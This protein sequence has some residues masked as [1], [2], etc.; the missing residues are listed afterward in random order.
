M[1][2]A[3]AFDN[4]NRLTSI[5]SQPSGAG[6][7][8][9]S[10]NYQYNQADQRTHAVLADGTYWDYSYDSL[11][12]VTNGV[13]RWA[14]DNT[15]VAGQDY[16]YA[17]DD[18]GNRTSAGTTA[19]ASVY[20]A[21]QLNQCTQRTVPGV[22]EISGSAASAGMVT[23]NNSPTV[24]HG[25]YFY[26]GISVPNQVSA[27]WTQLNVVAVLKNAGSNQQDIVTQTTGHKFV[28]KTPEP[29]FY[30][31]DGSLTND[32]RWVYAWD[33]ENRLASMQ[34]DTNRA[35]ASVPVTR[36]EF[37]YDA[38]SRR[39]GKKVLTGW[40]NSSF[41]V[42][43]TTRFLYDGW[44][45]IAEI[46][47]S[48]FTNSY[49]WGLDLSGTFQ[50]AGG[51]GGLLFAG[52]GGTGG[53]ATVFYAYDGNGNVASLVSATDGSN[54]AI[55]EYSPFGETLRVT[56]ALA[57]VSPFRFS[58]KYLDEETGLYYYGYRYYGPQVGR[59]LSRDPLLNKM[60]AYSTSDG[61]VFHLPG[62]SD[63][64]IVYQMA[65]NDAVNHWDYLGMLSLGDEVGRRQRLNIG[66]QC[67]CSCISGSVGVSLS[68]MSLTG[69]KVQATAFISDGSICIGSLVAFGCPCVLDPEV[70]WWDCYHDAGD[71][72][73]P[74]NPNNRDQ[75]A[76]SLLPH[77]LGDP[78]HL[79]MQASVIYD[80]CHGG[81]L[82]TRKVDVSGYLLWSWSFFGHHWNGPVWHPLP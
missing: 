21:N 44:N 53:V 10:F 56:G 45:P 78:W 13:R 38:Q 11:G 39:I 81:T 55:Y 70:Y 57:K 72:Y 31:A 60:E 66:R 75:P 20:S 6:V 22:A 2:T 16:R 49:V 15:V 34:T 24:R 48:G 54:A 71:W 37:A 7:P 47:S 40:T 77:L 28:A 5:D 41:S 63:E 32:G 8:H 33:G 62:S 4:L 64:R 27:V 59:W 19:G 17:F 69:G 65:V 23:V 25:E 76:H 9:A 61:R 58:S 46:T 73:G 30:D 42:T 26:G 52:F 67:A 50:N 12:Q 79:A 36:M 82:T 3:R 68:G 74:T 51:I 80:E 35:G 29:F 43:N 14:T 18:I 1:T